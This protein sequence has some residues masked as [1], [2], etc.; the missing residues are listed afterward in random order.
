MFVVVELLG[1]LDVDRVEVEVGEDLVGVRRVVDEGGRGAAA[2]G[3]GG[4]AREQRRGG[5]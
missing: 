5:R 3:G 4:R 1:D 2:V